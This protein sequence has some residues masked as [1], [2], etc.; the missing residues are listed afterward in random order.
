MPG[1]EAVTPFFAWLLEWVFYGVIA[2]FAVYVLLELRMIRVSSKAKGCR[3]SEV[4]LRPEG[5][6][7]LFPGVAVLLPVCNESGVIRRLVDAVCALEYPREKLEIAV[8]DDST[9]VT[10]DLAKA[11]VEEHVARGVSISYLKRRSR[12]C[13]KAGNLSY[14]VAQIDAEFLAIF[15]ADFV[16]PRD[17]LLK[18]IPCFQD[19]RLGFLQTGIDYENRNASFLTQ[20]Q[21]MEMGHQ[22]FVTVG[23]SEEGNMASL[24]G[25]S[26][27]WRRACMEAMGGWKAATATEDVDIGYKAQLGDWKYAYLKDVVSMSI[28][29]ETVSAFRVQRERWGRGLIHSAFRHG[30]RMLRKEMPLLKRLHAV[31]MMFSSLLLASIYC[32]FLLSLPLTLFMQFE[33]V[34]FVLASLAFFA[35]VA[36]WGFANLA[37]SPMWEDFAG[38][39]G[40]L[41]T[42]PHVYAYVSL[43]LPMAL[44]Y[45]VGGIRAAQGVFEEF[46]RTPKCG[47]EACGERPR[48]DA[49]LHGGEIFSFAYAVLTTVAGVMTGNVVLLPISVT[50]CLGFGMI[51]RWGMR[52]RRKRGGSQ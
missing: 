21:A 17:F 48:I 20:F 15:D 29:P 27:V 40:A 38:G 33:G 13:S 6:E 30:G 28:L 24:S 50:A 46:N 12:R 1:S 41:R 11:L 43:F 10:S 22:Q 14:G 19:P 16:P 5:E 51:L 49:W 4:C 18:T 23:L 45:F 3:L 9:D 26:C 34:G 39:R 52:D 42:F 25:S 37:G 2:C 47:D 35:L 44:Y 32:L 8:L 36:V 7:C 31:S